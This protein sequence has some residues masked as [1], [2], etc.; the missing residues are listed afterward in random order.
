MKVRR[1]SPTRVP[2]GAGFE[3]RTLIPPAVVFSKHSRKKTFG[4]DLSRAGAQ[5]SYGD[6]AMVPRLAPAGSR[7]SIAREHP[8]HASG[9]MIKEGTC[10]SA[11]SIVRTGCFPNC[12][13]QG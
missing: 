8:Q 13:R 9:A 2:R 6:Y 4:F 12:A 5:L 11:P 3:I 10:L 7:Q 1:R